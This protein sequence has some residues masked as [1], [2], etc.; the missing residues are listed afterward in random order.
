MKKERCIW[1]SCLLLMAAFGLCNRAYCQFPQLSFEVLSTSNGLSS[2]NITCIYQDRQGF[3]WVGTDFGLNK[4]DGNIFENFFAEVNNPNALSGNHI[5]DIL[6]DADGIFWIATKDGGLTRYNPKADKKN[7]FLQFKHSI[8]DASS[9]PTNRLISLFDYDSNY[10]L[11]GAEVYP[12]IFVHKK[13]FS[14]TVQ[15]TINFDAPYFP[16]PKSEVLNSHPDWMHKMKRI[17][18]N[19]FISNLYNGIV[20]IYNAE[21]ISIS[22]DLN[23]SSSSS[24]TDFILVNNA[25]WLASWYQGLYIKKLQYRGD[26]I[27][28]SNEKVLDLSDN[29]QCI[30][31]LD[32]N[33]IL[34]GSRTSGLYM[35][36][37]ATYKYRQLSSSKYNSYDLPSNNINC[38]YKD[39]HNNIW[40]GTSN[41]LAKHNSLL[42]NIRRY[43]FTENITDVANAFSVHIA[44]DKTIR[45][46]TANGIFKKQ[47][48]DEKFSRISLTYQTMNLSP[49]FIFDYAGKVFLATETD[50]FFYDLE[51]ETVRWAPVWDIH[52]GSG[53]QKRK[54][55][56]PQNI[57]VRAIMADTIDG[58]NV[59]L[60]EILGYG[61]GIVDLEANERY[62][63]YS[64]PTDSFSIKNNLT[65]VIYKDRTGQIWIGTSEG[66]YRW[67]K[68]VPPQNR[69]TAYFYN[70]LDIHSLS[71][72]AVSGIYADAH[73][74]LWI[75]TLD[76][77][78]N[79]LRNGVFERY[80]TG[81]PIGNKMFGVYPDNNGRLWC[82]VQFG[83]E[84]FDPG[85]S[86]FYRVKLPSEDFT[87][88]ENSN[89]TID[90]DGNFI[91]ASP[92]ALMVFNP[93]DWNFKSDFPQVYLKDVLL[94][95]KSINVPITTETIRFSYN[96]N[97]I[98]FLFSA[99]D[100]TSIAACEFQYK[101]SGLTS[102][103][104]PVK[105]PNILTFNSLPHG[106]YTLELRVT[107]RFGQWSPPVVVSSF[108]ILKPFWLQWWFFLVL[109]VIAAGFIFGWVR[110]R[111]KQLLK[112]LAV[113]N[114]IANDLHDEVGSTLSTINL[115]SEVAKIKSGGTS[116]ELIEILD[117]ISASSQEMQENMSHIVWSL[118]PRNDF[119][120][121][122][123]LKLKYIATEILEPKNIRIDF[124]I[125]E[126][127][128]EQKISPAQRK[129]LFLLYKEVLNNIVKYAQC[130]RV[131]IRF[132]KNKH[133]IL[134]RI[135]DNGIG[136]DTSIPSAGNGL[137]SI[138]QRAKA[139]NGEI[140]ITSKA[141]EGTEV[142][143]RFNGL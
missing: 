45:V 129:E 143:L 126:T 3:L 54:I 84:V 119:F 41:G 93:D 100:L 44:G 19:Y 114:K 107:N 21:G 47:K 134:M 68:G 90:A 97:F 135:T 30:L 127:F 99:L 63:V 71:G 122:A 1:F 62:F 58:E 53:N 14:L 118:Q 49:N 81:S 142:W 140:H 117:K 26:S 11:A 131:S 42:F 59:L 46:C 101:L 74:T 57:Q 66:L 83:F 4:F 88:R 24:V 17:N 61:M 25:L 31:Q 27:L 60:M 75:S 10:I 105:T 110:Y 91:Y 70:A 39:S 28:I 50:V 38:L 125:D 34:A 120:D 85:E 73:N 124:Q 55:S 64:N 56:Q 35:V 12:Y 78:L 108:R 95:N 16:N 67:H 123:V 51:N 113:R 138:Q 79:A 18:N 132:T 9:I 7:Q 15:N 92:N 76:G 72:N 96:Q 32:E 20:H 8:N 137:Y 52:D 13:N 65:R 5:V 40:V 141:G 136:F 103:W 37:V 48:N 116:E 69:F 6:Q 43:P 77:G 109:A 102:E 86:A 139:L 121:Q 36:D 133:W 98:T 112:I 106:T 82:P 33:T 94:F 111:E 87:M 80:Y 128:R 115:Y 104:L 29:I 22:R 2:N 23:N 89:L 130:S